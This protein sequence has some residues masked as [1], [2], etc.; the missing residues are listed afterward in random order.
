MYEKVTHDPIGWKNKR[1]GGTSLSAEN[2]NK[3]DEDIPKI[4]TQLDN[5]YQDLSGKIEEMSMLVDTIN[6]E[7][8]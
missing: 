2:L 4:A 7:V 8:I 3:M 1:V 6:G 5:A